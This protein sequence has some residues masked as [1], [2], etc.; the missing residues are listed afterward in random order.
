MPSSQ[1]LPTVIQLDTENNTM[2]SG[3]RF[4]PYFHISGSPHPYDDIDWGKRDCLI[5]NMAGEAVFEQKNV[6]V[7]KFW[8]QNAINIVASKYF[9]GRADK[10]EK[11]TSVKQLVDRVA[12]TISDWGVADGYFASG[13][14]AENFYNDLTYLLVNQYGV[15]NSPVWFNCG[16]DR[17][18]KGNGKGRNYWNKEAGEVQLA[19]DGYSHPQCSA[20]FI[21]SV[22]DD[23]ESIL[24]LNKTE[25]MLFKY[26]SG[27]GVNLSA[28]R[29]SKEAL[30]G[31]G[32]A[33]GPVT[34]MKGFDAFA[35]VI[36]SGGTTRR[37]AKMVILNIDHPDI[38]DFIWCKVKEER[39]AH[40][41]IDHGYDGALD[42]EIYTNIFFQNANNSVRVPDEFMQAV[43][44]DGDWCTN[45]VH[46]KTVV[47]TF[48]ARELI[49]EISEAAWECGDPG[50]QFDTTINNWHTC[51]EVERIYASNPCSEYM[52]LNDTACNLASLNLM[53]FRSGVGGF[54]ISA[55]RQAVR[56][57]ITAQEILVDNASYPTAEIARRSHIYRTLGLGYANLGALLMSYGLP[58]DSAEGRAYAGAITA[59]M[60]GEAYRQS[61]IMAK[62]LGAFPDYENNKHSFSRVMRQHRQA[63]DN[64]NDALVPAT[65][66][67]AAG[68]VWD[69]A[70]DFGN[71]YGYR[72][73]QTTVLAPT[74]TIGF[75]MDCATTG[76]EPGIALVSYK[77][78]VGGGYMKLVN[79]DVSLALESLSYDEASRAQILEFL[80]ANDTIEGA[81][82][83]AAKHWPVFDCAFKPK[84]GNRSIEPM[85]HVR[86]MAA[87]Q[88]FLS[89]A[90]SKT[91]NMPESATVEDISNV[92][93][94]GWKMGLKAI[95][96]YRDGCKRSQP[97]NTGKET[98]GSATITS[99]SELIE[100]PIIV[101]RPHRIKLPNE[102]SSLTHKF[103]IAG[104]EGYVTVGLY[105]DGSAGEVFIRMS[106]QGS[107]LAGIMDAFS[108]SISLNLQYGVPLEVL[109]WKFSHIRFEPSGY[110][111]NKQIP[112]A[113]SIID[114]IFRWLAL[115]FLERDKVLE[116]QQIIDEEAFEIGRAVTFNHRPPSARDEVALEAIKPRVATSEE[117]VK[118]S[119][120][121][122]AELRT[123]ENSTDAPMCDTCGSMMIRS[124]AC[125][126]CLECGSTS[127]CS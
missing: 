117:Q 53:K 110:T 119:D 30:S 29:S 28:L 32:V 116:I 50:L 9:F 93:M 26:G 40:V 118:P 2:S 108:I 38:K 14:D 105:D 16:V 45:S 56:L 8:S 67:E 12:R 31:G 101:G 10:N 21:N 33:S 104:H 111:K 90:I 82:G 7:P 91:V 80:E 57:L 27:A 34:F 88:P 78:L 69:E 74:G 24:E 123:F 35:G 98:K 79:E 3:L 59:I 114:Y 4:K 1:Q 95:A 5:S 47:E 127:G 60:T 126:K 109:I 51:L 99:D 96:I 66:F 77:K 42:G 115:K 75:M 87:V 65:L 68:K 71:R 112:I 120:Q 97:L 36:K 20:C 113:K 86:M 46:D 102:R 62:C 39:K 18:T 107:T 106:K 81:P 64:I 63:V 83:L 76:V 13:E 6:E 70:I 37:A 25:G 100:A 15:F 54:N 58:Y 11:E 122:A 121:T 84:N 49:K 72:N 17:Y 23:I 89:G 125:Y 41:L 44:G 94:Q 48:K 55:F 61:A 85:G 22:R 124:G 52:F 103:E 73:A 43:L 92:Y 19:T